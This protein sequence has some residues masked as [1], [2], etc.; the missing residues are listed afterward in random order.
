MNYIDNLY[1][2]D[3][4]LQHTIGD[5]IVPRFGNESALMQIDDAIKLHIHIKDNIYPKEMVEEAIKEICQKAVEY[6]C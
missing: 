5:G 1:P 6:F 4:V 2:T 3:I